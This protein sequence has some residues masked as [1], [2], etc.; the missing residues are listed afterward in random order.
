MDAEGG[1]IDGPAA[2][3][4]ADQETLGDAVPQEEA[5]QPEPDPVVLYRGG[6]LEL[7]RW[8]LMEKVQ[9]VL[10]THCLY[11]SRGTLLSMIRG[12]VREVALPL[13]EIVSVA[14]AERSPEV[15]I[16]TGDGR[17]VTLYGDGGTKLA[18]LLCALGIP[19]AAFRARNAHLLIANVDLE[20]TPANRPG[21]LAI[22]PAGVAYA[23]E[24]WLAQ[25]A[26]GGSLHFPADEL[27]AARVEDGDTLVLSTNTAATR[28][29]CG[30]A[31]DLLQAMRVV[32]ASS[33]PCPPESLENDGSATAEFVADRLASLAT[34]DPPLPELG[35]LLIATPALWTADQDHAA[36]ALVVLGTAHLL[37]LP[38][39]PTL[40]PWWMAT[41]R[42]RRGDLPD[43]LFLKGD[44]LRIA[45]RQ[46]VTA[47]RLPGGHPLIERFWAA[48]APFHFVVPE[49]DFKPEQWRGIAGPAA[50]F[51]L[52]PDGL[53]EQVLRPAM[54]VQ[55][56][57][58]LGLVL[59]E[60]DPW[61][62]KQ[63]E[64]LRAEVSRPRGVF[65]FTVQFLR[66][67]PD[68]VVGGQA[69]SALGASRDDVLRL[70]VLM[71]GPNPPDLL[72]PKRTLLRLPTDEAARL[73]VPED[74]GK[75]DL[76]TTEGRAIK[77]RLADLSAGGCAVQ[78]A[79]ALQP[80][81]AL[82]VI[83]EGGR[84]RH[85][86][87]AEVM[88]LRTVPEASRLRAGLQYEVGLRFM[89]LNESRLSWLQR[90]VLRRQRK[91]V[92]IRAA[93]E[94]QDPDALPLLDRPYHP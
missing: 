19:N 48:A 87:K 24:G 59:R 4:S 74:D 20:K 14:V 39:D 7:V 15:T 50:F 68:A 36:W 54:T 37:I 27:R 64:F 83:P 55:R 51:R 92:A 77:G 67:D 75:V 63:G 76:Q 78:I 31:R 88:E 41:G 6:G 81:S 32:L 49:E 45:D 82:A 21:T 53:K 62:F 91:R 71:P 46:R 47:F 56:S 57:D 13:R 38:D 28:F 12:G 86:F 80:G 60:S 30:H 18:A 94:D 44:V 11:A 61:T 25:L 69:A 26:R 52:T 42:V 3:E 34:L 89:G 84:A 29:Q 16:T 2:G 35:E 79:E 85:V 5:S 1:A 22:G 72:P 40:A 17:S 8:P 65:R 23:P 73:I 9:L 10:D 66:M 33:P 70:A 43:D 58:G 90:E 93:A